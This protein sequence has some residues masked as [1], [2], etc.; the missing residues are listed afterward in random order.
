M[1]IVAVAGLIR[2]S[3][4]RRFWRLDRIEFWVA[5][6]TAAAG[7][8]LGLLAAVVVGVVLT[9]GLVLRELDRVGVTELHPTLDGDDVG[10]VGAATVPIPGLL[11]LR[12][13]GPLYTANVR[14]ANRRVL[15]AVDAA[16]PDT[17]VLDM[18][19]VARMPLTALDH[20]ADLEAELV[21]RDV[22]CWIAGLPPQSL[23]TARQLPRWDEMASAGR[24][25]PTALAA[26]RA[27]RAE[28]VS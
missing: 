7:L 23:A 25:F 19:A 27:F 26:V 8:V 22:R 12:F 18:S 20:F 24:L 5:V 28:R 16:D 14:G 15:A 2:P 10:I 4:L 9:L 11:V 13:D 21:G 17:L 3:E 6:V 1:V